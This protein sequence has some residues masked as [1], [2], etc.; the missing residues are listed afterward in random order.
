MIT[1]DGVVYE[2]IGMA[3]EFS[4]NEQVVLFQRQGDEAIITRRAF[5]FASTMHTPNGPALRYT[6]MRSASPAHTKS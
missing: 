4:T 3:R 1:P 2:V 5:Y 6:P